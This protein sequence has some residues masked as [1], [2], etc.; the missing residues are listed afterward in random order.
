M[1]EKLSSKWS[2]ERCIPYFQA[3]T[4]TYAPLERLKPLYEE[5]L[6]QEGVVGMNIATRADCLGEGVPEYLAEIAERTVLTVELGLQTVHDGTAARINR[7]HT[8]EEFLR[9]YERLRAASVRI[10]ICVHLILGL[11]GESAEMM[12]ETVERVALLRPDQVKLHL[13]HVLRNTP[14]AEAVDKYFEITEYEMNEIMQGRGK[15]GAFTPAP[16]LKEFLYTLKDNGVKIGLVTSGLYQKA[17][18]EILNA[19]TTLDMGDP[20]EFYDAIIT[21]GTAIRK[22]QAGTLGELEAKP[23]PWLYAETARVGL[24]IPFERRHK[25]I[26][27]EDSSAGVEMS[28]LVFNNLSML[29]V[30]D[31]AEKNINKNHIE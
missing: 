7:G 13:L 15:P 2:V 6:S 23:H 20:V 19:F 14:L 25:V 31:L 11:P 30:K 4:N 3:F 18:P 29:L 12:M 9:G 28:L 10:G 8:F 27:I 1:R 22:G 17:W 5:A 24:G 26:G 16:D 21:A